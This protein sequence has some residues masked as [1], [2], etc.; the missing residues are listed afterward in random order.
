MASHRHA[1]SCRR[2]CQ[3]RSISAR[4]SRLTRPCAGARRLEAVSEQHERLPRRADR[5]L[6][7]A[8]RGAEHV[9]VRAEESTSLQQLRQTSLRLKRDAPRFGVLRVPGRNDDLVRVPQDMPVLDLEHLAEAAASLEGSD[10]AV[11]H[12]AH[13]RTRT[14]RN[15]ACGR[16]PVDR[17]TENAKRPVH[18]RDRSRL[19]VLPFEVFDRFGALQRGDGQRAE[20]IFER[21]DAAAD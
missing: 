20:R 4:C 5:A 2:S 15:S 1:A 3:W 16:S 6:I 7:L 9:C 18:G 13:Q 19:A 12:F 11:T 14:R 10:D 21:G 17:M 8:R